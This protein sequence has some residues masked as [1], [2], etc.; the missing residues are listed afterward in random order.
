MNYPAASRGVSSSV[1][2]R[3]SVLD[4]PAP[5]WI[6]GNPVGPLDTGFRRYDELVASRGVSTLNKM[7]TK[8]PRNYSDRRLKV[9]RD[10]Y[11]VMIGMLQPLAFSL[12]TWT[13]TTPR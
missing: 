13:V 2:A 1:L 10:T 4:T 3:H 9:F 11:C 8:V 6:R 5:Y 12:N 7:N